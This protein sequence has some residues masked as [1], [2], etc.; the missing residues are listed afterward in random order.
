MNWRKIALLVLSFMVLTALRVLSQA[1][2]SVSEIAITA[3][4]YSFTPNVIRVKKD[5]QVK[6][7]I[8]AVDAEHGFKLE[9]FQI[10][11]KLKK[12]EVTSIEFI[13]DKRG[14]FPFQRSHFCGFGHGKMKGQ[15]IVE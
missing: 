13:A 2:S 4:K 3:K 1:A 7:V 15:L 11:K 10:E 8:T 14:T 6:L 9:A 12:G 5:D